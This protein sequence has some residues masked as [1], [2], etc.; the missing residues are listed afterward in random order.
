ML[1]SYISQ[2]FSFSNNRSLRIGLRSETS[3]IN[4]SFREGIKEYQNKK[5]Y[6]NLLYD[7]SYN[8]TSS[9]KWEN[10]ITFRKQIFRPNYN[11]LNPFKR[12]GSDI[13]YESGD[14]DINPTKFFAVSYQTM[15]NK[16]SLFSL[17]GY[18]KDFTSSFYDL[19]NGRINSTYKNFENLYVVQA[20][21]EYNNAFLNR[22][23]ILKASAAVQYVK[24]DDKE[25]N[26]MLSKSTPSLIFETNNI[27]NIGRDFKLNVNYEVN[28]TN[29]DGLIKHYTNQ[30]LDITLSKKIN[31]NLNIMFFAYDI[32]K[33]N[34]TWEETTV[35]NYFYGTKR[36]ADVRSFGVI[37]KWNGTG[38]SYK[39]GNQE[40]TNDD[41]IDLSLIHI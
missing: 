18:M 30:K 12:V 22:K 5:D 39:P 8:W 9:G 23:W 16:W 1:A 31:S 15:K 26:R 20:G 3:Y 19:E 13:T 6:T 10:N 40:K 35:P 33:T 21:T 17:A 36:Y 14:S 29:K 7:V 2:S 41:T 25:Y 38:K 34:R 37:L 11:Y 28:P 32:L 4:Y 27:I 24:I